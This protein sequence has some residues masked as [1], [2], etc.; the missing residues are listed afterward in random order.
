MSD[1]Y[2]PAIA[3]YFDRLEASYGE[4]FSFDRLSGDELLELERLGREAIERDMQVSAGEKKALQPLLQLIAMQ[5]HKRGLS[6]GG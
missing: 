4:N 1:D 5:K 2:R 3:D 6:A